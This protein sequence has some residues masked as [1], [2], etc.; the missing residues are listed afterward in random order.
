[1]RVRR[2]LTRL[3]NL[4]HNARIRLTGTSIRLTTY[5]DIDPTA[6]LRMGRSIHVRGRA[7]TVGRGSTLS[8]GDG[9][10]IDGN[11]MIGDQCMVSIDRN[12]RLL[13]GATLAVHDHGCAQIGEYCLIEAGAPFRAGLHVVNGSAQLGGNAA[14]RGEV[15]VRGGQF[16]LGS[17]TFVNHGAEIRCEES[18]KIGDHVFISYFAD[19]YDSNTHS[20]DWR[21]RRQEVEDGYP[22]Q[23]VRSEQRP[24]TAPVELGPDV[25]VGKWAAV[26]KGCRLGARTV[27][28]TRAVV[29][30]SCP[31]DSLLVGN[32]A[33]VYPLDWPEG[34]G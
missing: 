23:T 18:V 28:G 10:L 11:V 20:L 21:A 31:E 29:T 13:G 9:A 19:I 22:N 4:R 24:R 14:I 5:V 27:V 8:I 26:L 2:V 15:S 32:P 30:V 17:N 16:W 34:G 1:M 6:Q 12:F 25:W 7:L 3:L 33:C